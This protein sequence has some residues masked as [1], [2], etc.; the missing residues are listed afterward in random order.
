MD[1]DVF[2]SDTDAIMGGLPGD[3]GVEVCNRAKSDVWSDRERERGIVI[4][5]SGFQGGSLIPETE[6]IAIQDNTSMS[7]APRRGDKT[8][9]FSNREAMQCKE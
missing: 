3:G 2:P 5:R 7:Y 4:L 9:C 6:T 1:A 8:L